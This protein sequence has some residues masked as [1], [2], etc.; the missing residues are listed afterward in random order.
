MNIGLNIKRGCYLRGFGF[1]KSLDL[2]C[3]FPL[4]GLADAPEKKGNQAKYFSNV[5]RGL[6]MGAFCR[7]PFN[8]H[9]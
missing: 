5:I 9:C 1:F 2:M 6:L 7:S 3:P 4:N 8:E